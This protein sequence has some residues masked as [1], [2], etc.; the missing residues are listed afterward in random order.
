MIR[1]LVVLVFFAGAV[2]G[3]GGTT[4]ADF[5]RVNVGE[6]ACSM[7]GAFT[8]VS[9]DNY[10]LY[11]NPAGAAQ[12]GM[13]E[14]S[15]S[16]TDYVA[17]IKIAHISFMN[18]L[19]GKYTVGFGINNL[20]VED[21]RRDMGGN[22]TGTFVNNDTTVSLLASARVKEDVLVGG[23]I[24]G[25]FEQLDT[26]RT[27]GLAI[28]VGVMYQIS[29]MNLGLVVQNVGSEIDYGNGV[30][31]SLPTNIKVGIGYLG[32]EKGTLSSD[33]DIPLYGTRSISIG[34]EYNVWRTLYIRAGYKLKEGGNDLGGLDGLSAGLGFSIKKNIINYALTPFGEFGYIHR[35]SFNRM[36]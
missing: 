1:I 5:V 29:G 12:L 26:E 25:L 19:A 10:C 24:K 31:A 14:L 9:N 8:G 20:Y 30:K 35:I 21:K 34:G 3:A 22:V 17:D 6:R 4:A 11:W 28:D 13:K 18:P 27:S 15:L 33:L 2:Y 7:G 36:F 16:H 32:S 23:V